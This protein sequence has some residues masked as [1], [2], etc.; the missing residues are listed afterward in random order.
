[1]RVSCPAFDNGERIPRHYT[2]DG[3]NVSPPLSWSDPP[4]GTKSIALI[5][6]DPDAPSGTF[7]HW[8]AWGISPELRELPENV[9][10][11]A[12]DVIQGTNGFGKIGYGGPSPPPGNP[13]RYFFRLYA[14]DTLLQLPAGA[15]KEQVLRAMQGHVLAQAELMGVYARR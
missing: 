9:K 10:P 13:H 11:G 7:V 15:T 2:A 8:L 14:L 5:C 3:E 6:D 4:P 12:R 1:M